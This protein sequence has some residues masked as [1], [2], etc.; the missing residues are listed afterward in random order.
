MKKNYSLIIGMLTPVFFG[1]F[2]AGTL[3][4]DGS[5]GGK[6]G[7]PGDNSAS[8]T[9]C[10]TGNTNNAQAWIT[11][12]IPALG[13]VVGETYTI[14]A[15]GTH[16]GVGRFGFELTSEDADGNKVGQFI[17]GS[18]GQTQLVNGNKA[19]THTSSGITPNGNSKTWTFQ[20]TAPSTD[21]GII[22][23][24]GAF[25]AANNNGGTS[26]DVVYL[27]NMSVDESSIG[28]SDG[29]GKITFSMSPNPSFGQ[30]SIE[31]NYTSPNIVIVDLYGKVVFQQHSYISK[32][33]IDLS[34]L[35]KGIYLVQIQN[36]QKMNTKKLLI[37]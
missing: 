31:H 8:C 26:G 10:H 30:L 1:L 4:H 13:Y 27:S 32:D 18:D 16:T 21:I 35:N 14:T 19:I 33:K 6:T 36:G 3:Y 28:I 25:N 15:I 12:D 11:S 5:P 37:K 34:F 7:S 29:M 24:Y 17:I 20:W 22:T 9:S 23:F 2:F